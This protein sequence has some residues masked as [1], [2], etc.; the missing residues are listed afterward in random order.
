[1]LKPI[2][3]FVFVVYKSPVTPE[4]TTEAYYNDKN[5]NVE[6]NVE[7]FESYDNMMSIYRALEYYIDLYEGFNYCVKDE[8]KHKI[9]SY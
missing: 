7:V 9:M 1:M 8:E 5:N 3:R 6:S 4:T 2:K